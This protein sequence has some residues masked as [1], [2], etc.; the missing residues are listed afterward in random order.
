MADSCQECSPGTIYRAL[1][2]LMVKMGVS[3]HSA[4]FLSQGEQNDEMGWR[5]TV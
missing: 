5:L 4:P 1:R 2:S 3:A